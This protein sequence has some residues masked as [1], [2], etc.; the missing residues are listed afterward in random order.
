[1]GRPCRLTNASAA[2]AP[3]CC[4]GCTA[5]CTAIT[6]VTHESSAAKKNESPRAPP[7]S[8]LAASSACVRGL[9]G[10]EWIGKEP[11]KSQLRA[12]SGPKRE[13][14][15]ELPWAADRCLWVEKLRTVLPLT[16]LRGVCDKAPARVGTG[17]GARRAPSSPTA[18]WQRRPSAAASSSPPAAP[19]NP[20]AP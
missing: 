16:A 9:A 14:V 20:V 12:T 5:G 13:T 2:M 15:V 8:T 17:R 6:R 1:V 3:H 19:I 10:D 4:T 11:I 7:V 18:R